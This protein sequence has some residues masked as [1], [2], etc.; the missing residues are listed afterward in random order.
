MHARAVGVIFLFGGLDEFFFSFN[1]DIFLSGY[2]CICVYVCA[3]FMY[4]SVC[5]IVSVVLPEIAP[6][7]SSEQRERETLSFFEETL[8]A[9][10]RACNS[11]NFLRKK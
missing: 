9:V 5:S 7:R 6:E 8:G 4:V 10:A 3:C 2:V 11:H 1:F